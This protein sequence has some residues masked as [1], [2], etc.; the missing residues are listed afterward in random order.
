MVV[1]DLQAQKVQ[2]A[3]QVL[4]VQPVWQELPENVEMDRNQL[5]FLETKD[6]L[7][8]KEMKATLEVMV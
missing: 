7:D 2:L 1:L 4:L 5:E 8:Q 3:N 6:Q